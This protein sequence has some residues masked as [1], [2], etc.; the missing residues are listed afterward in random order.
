M[1]NAFYDFS[2][3][4]E[5]SI[6]QLYP[7]ILVKCCIFYK[8]KCEIRTNKWQLFPWL[9]ASYFIQFPCNTNLTAFYLK[10][11]CFKE[12]NVQWIKVDIA[13]LKN[14]ITLS[15]MRAICIIRCIEL[16]I[17]SYYPILH[18]YGLQ[19]AIHFSIFRLFSHAP[20]KRC[21][22]AVA[23]FLLFNYKLYL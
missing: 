7:V 5:E 1:T 22:N 19:E 3:L 14:Y 16:Q 4:L 8:Q 6:A 17:F 20:T 13:F 15:I 9:L 11:I 12:Y 18:K 10:L 2:C 21:V 23:H